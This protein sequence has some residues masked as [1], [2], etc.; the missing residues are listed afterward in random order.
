[1][2][3]CTHTHTCPKTILK[4]SSS[5]FEAQTSV[6]K[7]FS[8]SLLQSSTTYLTKPPWVLKIFFSWL[9]VT[10]SN[11]SRSESWG[12]QNLHDGGFKTHIPS[13]WPHCSPSSSSPLML[14]PP[15]FSHPY[16]S[17]FDHHLFF[18]LTFLFV[19]VRVFQINR[20]KRMYMKR[21]IRNWPVQRQ[22]LTSPKIFMAVT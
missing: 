11:S 17:F 2:H 19:L 6:Y 5:S 3:T 15:S 16:P 1:M 18:Q 4:K 14:Y 12:F 21:F 10:L 20:N 7:A 13:L 22:R 8:V 9:T